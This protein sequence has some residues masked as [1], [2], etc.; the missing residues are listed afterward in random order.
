MSTAMFYPFNYGYVP[1]TLSEDNDPVDA[2][3]ITPTPLLSGSIINCRPIA[4][5]EMTDESGV[6]AKILAVPDDKLSQLYRNIHEPEDIT[7]HTLDVISHFFKHYKD[8]E[9]GKWVKVNGWKDSATAKK[10]IMSSIERYKK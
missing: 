5:L 10:E 6:D 9:E 4:L 7:P 3:V 1:Q 2:L 8:L